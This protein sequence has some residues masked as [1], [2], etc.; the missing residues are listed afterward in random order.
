MVLKNFD[1]E[2]TQLVPHKMMMKS[3]TELTQ[4]YI[5]LWQLTYIDDG[6]GRIQSK[7]KNRLSILQGGE[8][9]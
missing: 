4:Y 8:G 2:T 7:K 5:N 9:V 1:Q 3:K 6:K